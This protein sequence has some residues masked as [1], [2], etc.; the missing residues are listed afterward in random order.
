MIN[1]LKVRF[2]GIPLEAGCDEA[3]RGCLAGPVV[4]AAV[5]LPENPDPFMLSLLNDSKKLT[6]RIRSELRPLIKRHAL[7]FGIGVVDNRELDRIN[8]LN[9]S[10]QAMHLALEGLNPQPEFLVIDGNRFRSYGRIPH[11]CIP[12]GDGRY[13]SVAAASVLAKTWRDDYM[14]RLHAE[15]PHYDWRTNKGYPTPAH[16]TAIATHGISPYH[17]LTFRPVN[18]MEIRY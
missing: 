15:Y 2:S 17:R 7:A 14:T 18:Q 16:K 1:Q 10:I 12:G 6:A 9:A 4:A 13:A 8:V 3:G 11:A 5:I